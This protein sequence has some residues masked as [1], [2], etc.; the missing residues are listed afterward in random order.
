MPT[1]KWRQY[2]AFSGPLIAGG[3]ATPRLVPEDVLPTFLGHVF[4]LTALVECGGRFGLIN[5]YD[6]TG[7]T[8]GLHQAVAVMP[9]VLSS[10]GELFKML[11]RFELVGDTDE[12]RALYNA[13][14]HEGW[15]VA[16]DGKLRDWDTGEL[17]KP[18][19]FRTVVTPTAGVVPRK[20]PSWKQARKWALLFYNVFVHEKYRRAQVLYGEEHLSKRLQRFHS[21]KYLD[22][23][24]IEQAIIPGGNVHHRDP[25]SVEEADLIHTVALSFMVNAPSWMYK[26]YHKTWQWQKRLK[27][28]VSPDSGA[29]AAKLIK[30][31]TDM[32]KKWDDDTKN[33]RYQR[34]RKH[35]MATGHWPR[36]LFVGSD[37]IMPADLK[38]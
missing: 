33:S 4:E 10:Q 24:T 1:V 17:I 23:L 36:S 6:G 19:L 20:G 2:K 8:A 11:H 27:H 30:N 35:A 28:H 13:L 18:A 25:F 7:V 29:F 31:L 26:A 37:A 21:K 38:G 34:T 16:S 5:M 15:Y 22:D 32:A 9:K 14:A 12:L 3:P